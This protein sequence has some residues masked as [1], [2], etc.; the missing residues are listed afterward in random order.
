MC[1]MIQYTSL[2]TFIYPCL[3]GKIVCRGF[4]LDL[5]LKNLV[6]YT[7]LYFNPSGV[8]ETETNRV[9]PVAYKQGLRRIN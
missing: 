5:E 3:Y 8:P 4:Q 6:K 1:S 2:F 9:I 7:A